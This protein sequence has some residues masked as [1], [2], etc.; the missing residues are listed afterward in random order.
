VGTDTSSRA[1][2]ARSDCRRRLRAVARSAPSLC[3]AAVAA[4]G[5]VSSAEAIFGM[6][7]SLT[8]IDFCST[9][10][11]QNELNDVR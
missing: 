10:I 1:A 8:K 5:K 2:Q 4:G 6:L 9:L 7:Q 3:K 11:S